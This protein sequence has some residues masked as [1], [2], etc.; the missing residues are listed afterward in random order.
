MTQNTNST[1]NDE[2]TA[3]Q[4]LDEIESELRDPN[5]EWVEL[6]KKQLRVLPKGRWSSKFSRGTESPP[7]LSGDR[8][9][10]AHSWAVIDVSGVAGRSSREFLVLH[11]VGKNPPPK[12]TVT[13]ATALGEPTVTPHAPSVERM[14]ESIKEQV[15]K[16]NCDMLTDDEIEGIR[17]E[18]LDAAN[19][20]CGEALYDPT[21]Y[22]AASY[23]NGVVYVETK[24]GPFLGFDLSGDFGLSDAQVGAVR[25]AAKP[26]WYSEHHEFA[27]SVQFE[28]E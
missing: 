13:R 6:S 9:G 8:G 1:G 21:I 24:D 28:T 27:A 25:W 14:R 18:W 26:D 5:R 15:E 22:A 19:V 10:P 3:K 16:R 4:V 17:D 23:Q 20:V 2:L 7:A 12:Q 11:E